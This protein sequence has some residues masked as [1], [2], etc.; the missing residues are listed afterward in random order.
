MN[1]TH[2]QIDL[3]QGSIWKGLVRFTIPLLIGDLFQQ[4]YN[5]ADTVIV[6]QFLGKAALAAVGSTSN[7]TN[8]IIGLF[9][10]FSVGAQIVIAKAFGAKNE[11]DLSQSIHT[12]I[13]VTFLCCAILSILGASLA[14]AMVK[15]MK[16]PEDVVSGALLYLRI[17]FGGI[18]GLILYNMGGGILRA[19]G[20]SKTPTIAII[21]SSVSNILMDLLFVI[22]FHW[23]IAGAAFATILAQFISGIF[24]LYVISTVPDSY[25]FRFRKLK[26]DPSIVRS[27]I[28]LGLP[29]GL[30]RTITSL[31]NVIVFSFINAFG[32][33]YMA[34]WTIFNKIHQF[35]FLPMEN[36]SSA[37]TTFT[38]QNYGARRK[39][40]IRQG[41][42]TSIIL[43]VGCS[44]SIALFLYLTAPYLSR[45]FTSD[46]GVIDAGAGFVRLI[47][48]FF[49]IP[50][51]SRVYAGIIRGLGDSKG[52]M[53]LML[54]GFVVMRQIYL[55]IAT[56][57]FNTPSF[58]ALAYPLG[59]FTSTLLLILYY[60]I[61]K[62]K[63]MD[64]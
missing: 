26:I 38:G 22:V 2:R 29:M 55:I 57:F 35:C 4:L 63:L 28:D 44:V 62:D 8:T 41:L 6:G 7:V 46:Q 17:Y 40:R 31:S 13:S 45:L 49:V 18:S 19:I 23:G 5:L 50:F 58:I 43:G 9:I 12:T 39:D 42:S 14:P 1:K 34:G 30:Q 64:F 11:D 56:R 51:I 33:T 54:F 27:I 52:P 48:P 20:D 60:N 3:T 47:C 61:R 36:F 53:F 16:T 21:L 25:A 59:W 24:L 37:I 15:L 10:G 32:S